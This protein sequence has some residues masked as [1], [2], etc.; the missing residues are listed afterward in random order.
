MPETLEEAVEEIRPL[1]NDPESLLAIK[2]T[3][4]LIPCPTKRQLRQARR[5]MA[6]RFMRK[7]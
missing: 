5:I 7:R 2:P 6:R 4:I 1:L 3:K